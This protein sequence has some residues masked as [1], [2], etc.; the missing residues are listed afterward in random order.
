MSLLFPS[1]AQ[2]C[3]KALSSQNK[4]K[5]LLAML[6]TLFLATTKIEAV[7][8]L[9]TSKCT[10]LVPFPDYIYNPNSQ[11]TPRRMECKPIS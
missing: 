11:L 8:N 7:V 4:P 10:T 9:T 2:V 6:P 1:L 3:E 5:D